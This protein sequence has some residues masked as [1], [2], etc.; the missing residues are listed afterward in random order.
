[1]A[2]VASCDRQADHGKD[3]Q[4]SQKHPEKAAAAGQLDRALNLCSN[5]AIPDYAAFHPWLAKKL[6][7]QRQ[8]VPVSDPLG[9]RQRFAL[10]FAHEFARL[11][12]VMERA[13]DT[14]VALDFKD[15]LKFKL[16]MSFSTQSERG[17]GL[18]HYRSDSEGVRR[19]SAYGRPLRCDTGRPSIS[20]FCRDEPESRARCLLDP[21]APGG[22]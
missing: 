9:A 19:R 14:G 7:G 4:I 13:R 5:G 6:Q 10:S 12:G 16:L 3:N 11:K 20:P 17:E 2:Q 18:P 22:G 8:Q 21:W 15:F 1:M